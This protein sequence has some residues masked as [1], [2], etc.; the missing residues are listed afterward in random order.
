MNHTSSTCRISLVS[1]VCRAL[2][3]FLCC[4]ANCAQS[5]PKSTH[6]HA[7]D[8]SYVKLLESSFLLRWDDLTP[9]F[10]LDSLKA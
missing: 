4:F 6:K 8:P 1:F 10:L 7:L 9:N 3:V 2:F 5:Q